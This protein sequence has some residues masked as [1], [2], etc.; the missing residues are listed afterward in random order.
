MVVFSPRRY[1]KAIKSEDVE[2]GFEKLLASERYAYEAMIQG[3]TGAQ[4]ALLR[5][6]AAAPCAKILSSEYIA[7]HKLTVGGVQYAQKKLVELDLIEKNNDVWRV[8]DPI[9]AE[10]LSRY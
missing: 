6:L 4:T 8:V 1:G 2:A 3:L 5:A 9:F 7:R 10:W